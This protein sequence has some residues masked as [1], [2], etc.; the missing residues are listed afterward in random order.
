MAEADWCCCCGGSFNL[1]EY[2]I[3]AAIGRRKRQNIEGSGAAV[4]ATGCPACML[5]LTDVLSRAG[6]RVQVKHAVEMYAE[7]LEKGRGDA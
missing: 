4:V 1:Q 3:S 5:Q 6:A 7:T 2:E